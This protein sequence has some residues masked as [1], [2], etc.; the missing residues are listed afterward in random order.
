MVD[1]QNGAMYL[2]NESW[3]NV[4]PQCDE[5]FYL[6]AMY[7]S[8]VLDFMNNV[9]NVCHLCVEQFMKNVLN[10]CVEWLKWKT[11]IDWKRIHIIV[12]DQHIYF[13]H[14]QHKNIV[15]VQH[16]DIVHDQHK[17]HSGIVHG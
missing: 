9:L 7:L 11:Q 6:G 14:E 12:H 3:S 4:S 16:R 15:H 8:Y 17:R 5:Q 10:E 13:I 2:Q 1:F